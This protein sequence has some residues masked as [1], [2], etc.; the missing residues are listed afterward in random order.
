MLKLNMVLNMR[1]T[2]LMM[3]IDSPERFTELTWESLRGYAEVAGGYDRA[4][5]ATWASQQ[6]FGGQNGIAPIYNMWNADGDKLIDPSTGR[7][8]VALHVNILRK[9]GRI[10]CL[11]QVRNLMLALK[12]QVVTRK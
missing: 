7:F 12:S 1:L 6:L 2:P 5:A 4:T 3:L 9:N 10:I 8:I 11:E